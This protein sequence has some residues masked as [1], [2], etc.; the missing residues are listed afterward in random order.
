MISRRQIKGVGV[1]K[2]AQAGHALDAPKS[3]SAQSTQ[4]IS[5]AI[6]QISMR[7]RAR[8]VGREVDAR[9]HCASTIQ[10]APRH[11]RS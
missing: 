8:A 3:S 7:S 9:E 11:V 4:K 1:L 5:F 10:T 2:Y 6:D